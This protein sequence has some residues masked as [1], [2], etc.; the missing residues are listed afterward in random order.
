[1]KGALARHHA[2]VQGAIETSGGYVF[3]I[4]GDAFCAAFD[5]VAAGVAAAVAAQ[6]AVVA[7][8]WDEP[9]PIRVRMAVHTG[10]ADFQAGA[11][12]SGEYVSGLTL[13]HASRL[14]STA[15]GGQIL[16]SSAAREMLRDVAL[17]EVELRDLGRHRL[18]DLARSEQV[19]QVVVPDLPS[20]FPPLASLEAV[21]H[22]LPRP[23]TSFVGRERAIADVKRQLVGARL[24]TLTGPGGTGKTRLSLQMATDLL[25]D[26]PDGVWLVELAPIADPALATQALAMV[27]GVREEAGRPL[28]ATLADHLRPRR[29]LLL[30]DNCEHLIDACARLADDLLRACSEVRIVA[31]SREPL[32]LTGEVVYR[33]PP[34]S[35]PDPRHVPT[36]EQSG[37][38][39]AIR[40]FVDRA[41]AVQPEFAL[42]AETVGPVVQITQRLDGIPLAIELA[43]A[44][45][46]TL[47]VRQITE[48]LNERFRLLTGGSRAALPRHQTLRGLIDWSHG[49]LTDMERALFRRLSAFVGGWTLEAVCAVGAAG[50][51]NRHDVIDLVGRLVDKSLVLLDDQVSERRYRLLETIRQYALEKLA[52]AAEGDVVRACHREFYLDLAETAAERMQGPEQVVWLTRLEADHDNLRTALRWSL[53]RGEAELGLRLGSALWLFWDTR[54][55]FRE[56][57]EWLDDLLALGQAAPAPMT[58]M[59]RRAL[60]NVLDGAARMRG[61]HS[62]FSQAIEFQRRGLAVWRELRDKR[63]IAEALNNLGDVMHQ[64]GD[65]AGAKPLVEESLALFQELGD[66]RGIAHAL[67]NLGAVFGDEGDTTRARALYEESVPLFEAIEDWR[68]L[69]HALDKLGALLC[70]QGDFARAEALYDRSLRLAE[71]LG[72]KHAFA[73]ALRNLG[74]IASN[75]QDH[76]RARRLYEDS[77]ARFRELNDGFCMATSLIGFAVAAHTAGDHE[78]AV[79]VGDQGLAML[80]ATDAKGYLALR[81]DELARA[82]LPHGDVG[83]A[84]RCYH[85]ALTLWVEARDAAGMATGLEGMA[86]IVEARGRTPGAQRLRAAAAAWREA[87]G[88]LL[89]A[90]IDHDL[91]SMSASQPLDQTLTRSRLS[92][93]TFE[94]ALADAREQLADLLERT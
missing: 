72:D 26:F 18:R 3:Q 34:L 61:R 48:H 53:D 1:M 74:S 58:P 82:A 6:R 15:H 88:L 71:E 21:P 76:A 50:G 63:G 29:A 91:N 25:T 20:V 67:I 24:L 70:R 80:R 4:V 9:G 45:V 42:T 89:P 13:S 85:E 66:R 73:T 19:F 46:R 40:L 23:L 83:R 49:L 22:N 43:A 16:V 64:C 47:S 77:V 68:G 27:L 84:A 55:Y 28:L 79:D 14:L 81:L 11:Y 69:A 17:Q 57:R 65:R 59:A 56:G 32:G 30:L 41:T 94:E 44:R 51:V 37:E 52:E 54:G 2:L 87:R 7:E 78:R 5:T 93:M 75:G 60:A 39:E 31:S 35:V 62:E 38:Y 12:K 92:T 90:A 33:V 10:D 8:P 36:I 86:R